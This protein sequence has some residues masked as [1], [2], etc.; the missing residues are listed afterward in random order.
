[1]LSVIGT[2]PL[3]AGPVTQFSK[4]LTGTLT[5][6]NNH[7]LEVSVRVDRSNKGTVPAGQR[8]SFKVSDDNPMTRVLIMAK[9]NT[10]VWD[11]SYAKEKDLTITIPAPKS[12]VPPPPPAPMIKFTFFN[13]TGKYVRFNLLNTNRTNTTQ[14]RKTDVLLLAGRSGEFSLAAIENSLAFFNITQPDGTSTDFPIAAGKK[15]SLQFEDRRV[16]IVELP[17]QP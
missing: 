15:Y 9:D 2:S 4:K 8:G 5:V 17:Q 10:V 7:N 16:K 11:M 14:D 12:N 6:I 1:L 3:A 13:N